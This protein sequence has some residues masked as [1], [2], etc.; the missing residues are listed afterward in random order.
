M[1]GSPPVA[2][3]RCRVDMHRHQC[4]RMAVDREREL[5]A[6]CPPSQSAPAREIEYRAWSVGFNA[7]YGHWPTN[8]GEAMERVRHELPAQDGGYQDRMA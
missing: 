3:S 2:A 7:E 8:K 5:D 6:T 1:Y 4:Q